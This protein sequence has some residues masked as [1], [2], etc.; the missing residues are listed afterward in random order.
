MTSKGWVGH[1]MFPVITSA[2][3][4]EL[5]IFHFVRNGL[6]ETALS[7][8]REIANSEFFRRVNSR[9]AIRCEKWGIN[10]SRGE[11]VRVSLFNSVSLY[12]PVIASFVCYQRL[13]AS[14]LGMKVW[15]PWTRGRL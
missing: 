1:V 8:A 3:M 11:C 7:V 9:Y 10:R 6:N 2:W 4:M 14:S 13:G 5:A 15:R 12:V